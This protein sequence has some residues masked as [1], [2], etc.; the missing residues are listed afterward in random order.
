[1][2][3]FNNYISLNF[4]TYVIRNQLDS[5]NIYTAMIQIAQILSQV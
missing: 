4:K 2:D 3:S 5:G 1:M